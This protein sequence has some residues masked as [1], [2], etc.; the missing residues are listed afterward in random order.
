MTVGWK[1]TDGVFPSDSG[2]C[3]CPPKHGGLR[4]AICLFSKESAERSPTDQAYPWV[5]AGVKGAFDEIGIQTQHRVATQTLHRQTLILT[6]PSIYR[7][8]VVWSD[9]FYVINDQVWSVTQISLDC[10]NHYS[11]NVT[12][13]SSFNILHYQSLLKCMG[14]HIY[15]LLYHR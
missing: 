6:F 7:C 4:P 8:R 11:S 2:L 10:D 12:C 15:H 14:I 9:A 5:D 1:L 3:P 13:K